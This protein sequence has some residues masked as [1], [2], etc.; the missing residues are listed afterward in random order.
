[1][2]NNHFCV[3]MAGGIGS[4]F[5]PLSRTKKP[6]QFLDILGTGRTLL[7]QTV[8]RLRK[9]IPMENILIVTNEDYDNLVRKQL[10]EITSRQVLLEPMRRN[11]A[12]CIAYA[13]YKI[14]LINPDAKILVAP[15]DH[16]ILKEQDFLKAVVKGLDFVTQNDSI[17]TLGIQPNRP[18][19][20]YGYIQINGDKTS[21][22]LNESFR[23]VKTFTE[24]PDLAMAEVFLQSGDF[25]WNS[26]MFFWSL[27][28][29]M[30]EFNTYLPDVDQLFSEG[31]DYYNTEKEGEFINRVYPNCKNISI[32][33]G[34]MEK[35][36]NVSVLCSDFG[37]SDLGTW[38][39]LYD[40]MDKDNEKNSITG[41]NV[42]CYNSKN[43]LINLP[44]NKLAVIQ[45]L[46]DYI[47]VE[48]DNILLVCRK[49]DE[50]KIKNFVNDVRLEKGEGV[51]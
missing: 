25:F 23:K 7:Q 8:D 47:I 3:I 39:S 14:K 44:D 15:S 5:W 17:L 9:V 45:G 4:R 20:G 49:Q 11:T 18:E 22:E 32:D 16:I 21:I 1:M 36:E 10:P 50:Q 13:N 26:G 51:I 28:T 19:T 41:S 30:K 48:S 43:C 2:N 24:K 12:P 29:I 33:Y 46:D 27:K 37:W 38:G 34:I 40:I 31:G 6:K 42:F 35:A